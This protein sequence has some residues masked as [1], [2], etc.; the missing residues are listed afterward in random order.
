MIRDVETVRA[1]GLAGLVRDS[2]AKHLGVRPDD[3]VIPD[4]AEKYAEPVAGTSGG[5]A[6]RKIF[7]LMWG[8]N[9][10]GLADESL[11]STRY[12]RRS[13]RDAL[14]AVLDR[15]VSAM[16][17][18]A[19]EYLELGPEPAKTT[20]IIDHLVRHGADVRGYTAVDINPYSRPAVVEHVREVLPDRPV[21]FRQELFADVTAARC[22]RPGV[23]NV[24]TMLGFEEGNDHPAANAAMLDR[25][26]APG[27]L[28]LSEMQLLPRTSWLPIFEFYS[29]APMREF[30]ETVLARHYG[31]AESEYGIYLLPVALGGGHRETMVAVTAESVRGPAR[32]GSGPIVVTNYC[33]KYGYDAYVRQR[34]EY[35]SMAVLAQES[36]A[37]GS[38]VFQ[39]SLKK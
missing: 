7:E 19:F 2:L 4:N 25:I 11:G 12:A 37:D 20:H 33:L 10:A 22:H 26:L 30:S 14:R 13:L 34:E 3:V 18:D 24:V 8:L 17:G 35:G 32:P 1:T 5:A 21:R 27:D 38:I 31:P 16:G 36:T 9:R 15:T 23:R 29:S 6:L 28:L 39:L